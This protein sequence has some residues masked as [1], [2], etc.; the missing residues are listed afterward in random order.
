[1]ELTLTIEPLDCFQ[2]RR[3]GLDESQCTQRA[4]LD[5][6]ADVLKAGAG[7][8]FHRRHPERV[9]DQDVNFAVG[10]CGGLDEVSNLVVVGDVGAHRQRLMPGVVELFGEFLQALDSSR[11]KHQFGAVSRTSV[12][13][14]G[15]EAR[16][17]TADHHYFF[18]RAYPS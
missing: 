5:G 15:A 2:R 10:R 16:P 3:E 18:R 12:R 14:R 8:R 13:Q 17:D 9:V 11:R 4:E 1:M 6:V 7:Q